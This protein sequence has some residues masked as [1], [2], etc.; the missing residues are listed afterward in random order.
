TLYDV[1]REVAVDQHWIDDYRDV[2]YYRDIHPILS[3]AAETSWV[4]EEA[5][6]GHGYDKRMDFRNTR[7]QKPPKGTHRAKAKVNAA[8]LALP[9]LASPNAGDMDR[10]F[11]FSHIREPLRDDNCDDLDAADQANTSY[12]PL[13]SGDGGDRAE[14]KPCTWLSVLPSQY[15]KFTLWKDGK[16]TTGRKPE[17]PPLEEIRD[18]DEQTEALQRAALEPCVGGAFYPG[19]EASWI[20]K[21]KRLYVD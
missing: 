9:V 2:T 19:V 8:L 4:N 13:L 20:V 12:M 10:A 6:R 17:F 18:P 14:G 5:Q 7:G 1:M 3:R 16:F 21:N 15:R 11:I